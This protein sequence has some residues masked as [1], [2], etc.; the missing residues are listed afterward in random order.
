MQFM[1]CSELV[2]VLVHN[3]GLLHLKKECDLVAGKL[4]FH[5]MHE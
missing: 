2:V 3:L 5:K 1:R 4:R